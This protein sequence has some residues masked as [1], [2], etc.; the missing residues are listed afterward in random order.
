MEAEALLS[1]LLDVAERLGVE[2][3]RAYLGG[4]GGGLCRLRGKEVLFLDVSA[5]LAEQ[6]AHTAAGLA[7]LERMQDC[8]LLP[9]V[10]EALD[11]FGEG[12]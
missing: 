5:S 7:S 2:V 4:E 3:R 8:F 12:N 6:L 11:R 9:E 10:R 1:E